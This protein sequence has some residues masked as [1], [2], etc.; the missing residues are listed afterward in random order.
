MRNTGIPALI[1]TRWCWRRARLGL[2]I[3]VLTNLAV[4]A[5]RSNIAHAGAPDNAGEG[6]SVG[7]AVNVS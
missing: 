5:A 4:S 7:L 3:A 2:R 1:T 6:A